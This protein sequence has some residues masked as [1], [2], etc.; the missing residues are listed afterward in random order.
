[1]K[2][3]WDIEDIKEKLKNEKNNIRK[4]IYSNMLYDIGF[5]NIDINSKIDRDV[6]FEC[7]NKFDFSYLDTALIKLITY[8]SNNLPKYET[9]ISLDLKYKKNPDEIIKV[10]QNFYKKNNK[11]SLKYLKTI[12]MCSNRI[13]FINNNTKKF[14]GRSYMFP[15]DEF[16]ILI[17]GDNYLQN[18]LTLIHEF[19]HVEGKFRGYDKNIGLYKELP[20]ILYEFYM[21]DYLKFEHEDKYEIEVL[22]INNIFKY[23][24]MIHDLNKKIET[25]KSLR[26]TNILNNLYENYDVYYDYLDFGGIFNF[27]NNGSVREIGYIIS[28]VVAL[29]IYNNSNSSNINNVITCY[30][31]GIYK[32]NPSV[33]NEVLNYLNNYI[34]FDE[35]NKNKIKFKK[36]V[37]KI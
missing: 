6:F 34:N 12:T 30:L 35:I 9:E 32:M 23:I 28:F 18:A 33:V 20:S 27:L 29:D 31:C 10:C 25:I 22:K 5:F 14:Y 36:S 13:H 21:L 1:M 3:Y 37:D 2:L 17:N 16:Y 24:N 19:K 26:D 15:D 4:N 7:F 8:M 11:E